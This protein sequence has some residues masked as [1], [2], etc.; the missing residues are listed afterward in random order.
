MQKTKI[1][2]TPKTSQHHTLRLLPECLLRS[3]MSCPSFPTW[4]L[5]PI[6]PTVNCFLLMISSQSLLPLSIC[7]SLWFLLLVNLHQT[8]LPILHG[9]CGSLCCSSWT[10]PL[11]LGVPFISFQTFPYFLLFFRSVL[12]PILE[13]TDLSH[14]CY[15][16]AQTFC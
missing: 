14:S 8:Y 12:Q 4:H 3:T 1:K 11:F 13:L 6:V 2:Q 16:V 15:S 9:L 10:H 5:F 7:S